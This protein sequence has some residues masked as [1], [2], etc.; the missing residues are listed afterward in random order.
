M[1]FH[2]SA[3]NPELASREGGTISPLLSL[4]GPEGGNPGWGRI[5]LC[6][7]AAQQKS[8]L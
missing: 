6:R 5:V 2:T 3:A 4:P 7:R 1:D 8:G